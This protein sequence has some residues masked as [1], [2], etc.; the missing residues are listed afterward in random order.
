MFIKLEKVITNDVLN[1]LIQKSQ[2][3][4]AYDFQNWLQANEPTSKFGYTEISMAFYNLRD[5]LQKS[6]PSTLT[7]KK[8]EKA[9]ATAPSK[10][11]NVSSVAHPY[12]N[13]KE[14]EKTAEII[15]PIISSMIARAVAVEGYTNLVAY[16]EKHSLSYG[17]WICKA[18]KH[19]FYSGSSRH[20]S[21]CPLK[22]RITT[23]FIHSDPEIIYVFGPQESEGISSPFKKE[24]IEK[25]KKLA[26]SN[27]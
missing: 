16:N 12:S 15:S 8:V 5:S 17:Y 9:M 1:S 19:S 27:L 10:S 11:Q 6:H 13:I 22:D 24:D 4:T 14:E 23:V 2:C 25:V 20:N 3:T 26:S 7:T 18:C 21:A